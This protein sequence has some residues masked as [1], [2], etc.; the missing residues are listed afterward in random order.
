M[1]QK[2]DQLVELIRNEKGPFFMARLC[3]RLDFDLKPGAAVDSEQRLQ[4]LVE[5]CKGLGYVLDRSRVRQPV[6]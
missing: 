6:K 5:A 3:L 4:Q 1:G 2:L